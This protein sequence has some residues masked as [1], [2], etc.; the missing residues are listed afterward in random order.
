VTERP[1]RLERAFAEPRIL[2]P[3]P[4]TTSFLQDLTE[5]LELV[6]EE[7]MSNR[8]KPASADD[9][10]ARDLEDAIVFVDDALGP[11]ETRDHR[12]KAVRQAADDIRRERGK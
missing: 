1:K 3:E 8:P 6:Q 10:N 4:T 2:P 12:G 9:A 7:T 11:L 5:T